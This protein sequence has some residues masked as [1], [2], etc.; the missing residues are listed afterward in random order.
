MKTHLKLHYNY[1]PSTLLKEVKKLVLPGKV[2]ICFDILLGLWTPGMCVAL[3]VMC[4]VRVLYQMS[5]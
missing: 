2:N 1:I 4:D 3:V 5:T